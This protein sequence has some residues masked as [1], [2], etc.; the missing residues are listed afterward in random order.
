MRFL[1]LAAALVFAALPVS[2]QDTRALAQQ[3][4]ALPSIQKMMDDLFAPEALASSVLAQLPP[5]MPVT[6]DQATRIGTI[7]SETMRTLRPRMTE[8]LISGSAESF[9]AD[10]LSALIGFYE[11]EHGAA[12]MQKMPMM[13]QSTMEQMAPDIQAMQM[14]LGPQI[15]AIL[16]E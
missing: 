14:E 1:P 13:M 16:R 4:A 9:T 3:Y 7:M 15:E 8:L 11:S 5:G 10:E 12:I 2:A 6:Q